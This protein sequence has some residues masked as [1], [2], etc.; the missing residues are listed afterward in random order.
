MSSIDEKKI[1]LIGERFSK[2]GRKVVKLDNRCIYS[3]A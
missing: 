3:V 2:G 1:Q